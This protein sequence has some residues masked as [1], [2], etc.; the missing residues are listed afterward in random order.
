MK[1]IKIVLSYI[2]NLSAGYWFEQLCIIGFLL[3]TNSTKGWNV[4]NED[5]IM[6]IPVGIIIL[7]VTIAVFIAQIVKIYN[8]ERGKGQNKLFR[9]IKPAA[10]MTGLVVYLIQ[11]M[12]LLLL[13]FIH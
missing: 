8:Y 5:G 4:A 13:D 1:T 7:L 3:T 2:L 11:K 9:Y 6:F 12:I 10:F